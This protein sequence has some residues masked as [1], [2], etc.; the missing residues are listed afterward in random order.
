[1][2]WNG[3]AFLVQDSRTHKISFFPIDGLC[4]KKPLSSTMGTLP[5]R[6]TPRIVERRCGGEIFDFEGD[7]LVL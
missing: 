5:G 2:S 7:G 1:M 4:F 6:V 3:N